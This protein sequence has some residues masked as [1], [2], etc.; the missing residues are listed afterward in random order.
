M[1]ANLFNTEKPK[2]DDPEKPTETQLINQGSFGCIFK[3]GIKCDGSIQT[4]QTKISKIQ[5]SNTSQHEIDIGKTIQTIHNY[6]RYFAP[7][8]E[9]CPVVISEIKNDEIKKCNVISETYPKMSFE[10]NTLLYV[11]KYT[12]YEYISNKKLS[13]IKFIEYIF[14]SHLRIL[15]ALNKLN[16]QNIIHYDLKGNNIMCKSNGNPIIIDFGISFNTSEPPNNYSD[17]FYTYAPEYTVWCLDIHI[18]SYIVNKKDWQNM[19]INMEE[20]NNIIDTFFMKNSMIELLNDDERK[21]LRITY[22]NYFNNLFEKTNAPTNIL[23]NVIENNGNKIENN[24]NKIENAGNPIAANVLVNTLLLYSKQWD[25]YSV[26]IIYLIIL[27]SYSNTIPENETHFINSYIKLMK[28]NIM[29]SPDK[30][31]S[32]LKMKTKIKNIYR[33]IPY[34]QIQNVKSIFNPKIMEKGST[35]LSQIKPLQRHSVSI[36]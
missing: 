35:K 28:Q 30:R 33:K 10:S 3:P 16:K 14:K 23:I 31:L 5:N 11:G 34:L 32:P 26:S 2:T 27:N 4:D 12:L 19:K 36:V 24:G 18:I 17:W 6:E 15:T 8:I 7:I 1:F 22:N 25:N 13:G 20:I 29:A 21:E 9:S